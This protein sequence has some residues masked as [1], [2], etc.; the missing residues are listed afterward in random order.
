MSDRDSSP[1]HDVT[2]LVVEDSAEDLELI[3][4]A[5]RDGGL[6]PA[7]RAIA[8]EPELRAALGQQLP[9]AILADWTLPEFSGARALEIARELAPEV[10]LL[11]VSGTISEAAALSALRQGAVDYV[12]KHQ[13]DKLGPAVIRAISEARSRRALVT[14][15]ERYR[16]LFET[17]QDGILILDADSG[18]ILEANP[19]ICELLGMEAAQLLGKRLRELGIFLDLQGALE[20]FKMQPRHGYV[21]HDNLLLQT[22][23]D[24][25]RE[26]EFVSNSYGAGGAT[27][28][29]CNIRDISD[30]RA[31]ERLALRYQDEV[32]QSL[33]QIVAALVSLNEARDPYTAGHELRVSALA[34]AIAT[35]M[36][37]SPQQVEGIRI[38]GL[39]HDI[40]KFTIPAEILTKPTRL[41]P[42]ELALVRTHAEAGYEALRPI[43]FPWP[44]AE[45][46][47]QHHERLDGSGYPRGLKGDEIALEARILAVADTVES[48]A[49][50]RPYRHSLGLGAALT[51]I[52]EG[53]G[54]HFD[55]E[56]V[57][58]CLRLFRGQ[59]FTFA[60]TSY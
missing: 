48:M 54:L 25:L 37:L 56:P 36:H 42:E 16:G 45:A 7:I 12:F 9:D 31:A 29:Q 44:V 17:A 28:M 14:S 6:Q 2:L 60:P 8:A 51:T 50:N 24:E 18:R 10:P 15:E 27:V 4:D 30:R 49:T 40:G 55:P 46:V 35:E 33:H 57:A 52:E 3:G 13:L 20:L 58:A 11:F 41:S 23:N 5:L 32:L 1:I 22:P 34:S 26:V 43:Q 21:R 39:L 47:R 59:G 38:S 53:Q 19:F